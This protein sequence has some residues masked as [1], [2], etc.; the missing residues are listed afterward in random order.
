M[1]RGK[2]DQI[3]GEAKDAKGRVERQAGEWTGDRKSQLK[4]AADQAAGKVQKAA[5]KLKEK[6][7]RRRR[8]TENPDLA[9]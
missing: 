3:Q 5:G 1:D 6:A 4:G 9:A 7:A 2:K 8:P